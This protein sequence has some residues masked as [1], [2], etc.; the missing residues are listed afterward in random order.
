MQR[1]KLIVL[2]MLKYL[3]VSFFLVSGLITFAAETHTDI[4]LPPGSNVDPGM[5][6]L[7][8]TGESEDS[9]EAE[10]RAYLDHRRGMFLYANGSYDE[11]LPYLI[12]AAKHGYKDSQARLAHLYLHGLG[13]LSR[14][15]VVGIAW[16]GVA[17]HGETTPIIQRHYDQLISAV[18]AK[19]MTTLKKVVEEYVEKYGHFDQNVV[20]DVAKHASTFI[21]KNRCYFEYEFTVMS[22]L[23]IAAMQEVFQGQIIPPDQN[24]S[25]AG[26]DNL[27]ARPANEIPPPPIPPTN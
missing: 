14:S 12:S 4:K 23:E 27:S 9:G 20:C 2:R 17:A 6:H 16:M 11:A 8:V 21:S 13:G 26:M 3:G 19:H 10:R 5:E 25:F 22:S 1:V 24:S 18:P 7:V 15:D